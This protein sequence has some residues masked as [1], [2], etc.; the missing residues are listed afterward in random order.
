[1]KRVLSA[2]IWLALATAAHG[3]AQVGPGNVCGNPTTQRA[4]CSD[5]SL[6]AMF[7]QAFGSTPGGLLQR[8]AAWGLITVLPVASGGTGGTTQA[9]ARTGLG[10]GTISTQNANAVAISG[11]SITGLPTP[12]NP[13]DAARLQDV[14]AAASGLVVIA[15]SSLA[16]AAVLPNTPTYANGTAGV[17]AT[18]TAGANSTLT[19]DGVVAA[20]NAVVLVKNQASAFQN[21]IYTVTTAGG[22]VPWVL[23]RATYFDQSTEMVSGSTTFISGG[24]T[25][26]GSSFTLQS[27]VTTVGTTAVIFNQGFA[28][29]ITAIGGLIGNVGLGHGLKTGSGNKILV[30]AAFFRNYIAGLTLST[31]GSSATFGIAPGVAADNSNTDLM[32]LVSAFT[33]T[34]SV[35]AA[36]TGVGALDAGTI[37]A[38]TW[39]HVFL[40][41]RPDTGAVDICISLNVSACVTG[42]GNLPF[43]YTEF[44]RIGSIRTDASSNWVL[45]S[46]NGDEFL[47]SAS[48]GDVLINNLSTAS[49]L[50]SLTVPTGVKVNAL[51]RAT[52]ANTTV[53]TA[54]VLV[55]S[56]DEAAQTAGGGI[57]NASLST[58]NTASS[59]RAVLSVR[60]STTGQIRAVSTNA[61]TSFDV[62]TYGWI[63]TR[64]KNN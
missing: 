38:N 16:T 21:G 5:A 49:I 58:A 28:A 24:T 15:S 3:Q 54:S 61:S 9:T 53:T 52:V 6:T 34:T 55:T 13:T 43:S 25:N 32:P 40:T 57:G 60:T 48:V 30:D 56:P 50:F 37:A 17:G 41:Q 2:L 39:Y 36:G 46:Q 64:G 1:M 44:R 42:I 26:I 20:L 8:G 62:A 29:G 4:P 22:A 12:V 33:K 45:F 31:A 35:W 63:D 7:D 51:L 19:V 10:L 23:T 11:G 59:A 18:L 27:A 47:W 14:A